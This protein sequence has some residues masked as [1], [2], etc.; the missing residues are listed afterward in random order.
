M[1]IIDKF[2][3][4]RRKLRWNKQY[5]SGRWD[6]LNNERESIRYKTIVENIEKHG[7]GNADILALGCGEGILSEH[8]AHTNFNSFCGMD[9]SSVSIKKANKKQLPK[10]K[11]ICADIHK[12]K[13]E[14]TYDV[15]IFNEV[16]YYIHQ[17]EKANVL[18]TM[19]NHLNDGGI[20]AISIY[21]EGLGCWE[22]FND[23]SQLEQLNFETIT[24]DEDLTYWKIGTYK[25]I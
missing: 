4:W 6:N 9:F 7:N 5:K 16:F 18:K 8:L 19:L 12:F 14:S 17:T 25:K 3:N 11:F 13:P 15:I 24:T 21:R 23:D 2:H 20:L 10:S 22:Y 1:N